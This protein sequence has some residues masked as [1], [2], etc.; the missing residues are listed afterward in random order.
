[1]SDKG[2]ATQSNGKQEDSTHSMVPSMCL[3]C[4]MYILISKK[5]LGDHVKK[6]NELIWHPGLTEKTVSAK[7]PVQHDWGSCGIPI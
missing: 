5:L 6:G 4:K 1:M 3:K 7:Q 2:G